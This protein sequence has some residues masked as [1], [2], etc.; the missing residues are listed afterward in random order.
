MVVGIMVVGIM[1]VGIMVVGIMVVG[2]MVVGNMI[3]VRTRSDE[4]KVHK[5]I[6][7]IDCVRVCPN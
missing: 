2:N 7:G 1:V 4:R 3:V 6:V 5:M